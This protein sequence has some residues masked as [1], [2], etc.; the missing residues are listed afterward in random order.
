M[1]Y[2]LFSDNSI[3]EN[4]NSILQINGEHVERFLGLDQKGVIGCLWDST[5]ALLLNR[6]W[7][8]FSGLLDQQRQV[9]TQAWALVC[10][11]TVLYTQEELEE[12]LKCLQDVTIAVHIYQDKETC[13]IL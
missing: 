1:P 10:A 13:S 8:S 12:R 5:V 4:L 9:L 7:Y 3:R 2:G 11:L 6:S